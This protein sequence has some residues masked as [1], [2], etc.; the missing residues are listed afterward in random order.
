MFALLTARSLDGSEWFR[1]RALVEPFRPPSP[2]EGVADDLAW[3]P[4]LLDHP[5]R[6]RETPDPPVLEEDDARV[7]AGYE[8]ALAV[9]NA[10]GTRVILVGPPLGAAL[11]AEECTPGSTVLRQLISRR[12]ATPLLDFTCAAVDERWFVDGHHLS[13][14]GRAR[15]SVAL[16]NAARDLP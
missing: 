6:G 15:Y 16:G 13:S 14:P 3:K 1:S 9:L 10:Q 8:R 5:E 12:T 7:L 4:E 11:R 2:P